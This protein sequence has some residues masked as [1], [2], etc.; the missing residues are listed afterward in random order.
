MMVVSIL[1]VVGSQ[2]RRH[3]QPATDR[4][5]QGTTPSSRRVTLDK[6]IGGGKGGRRLCGRIS[7]SAVY[8]CKRRCKMQKRSTD[9]PEPNHHQTTR[10][11]PRPHPEKPNRRNDP[12]PEPEETEPLGQRNRKKPTTRPKQNASPLWGPTENP[13]KTPPKK[14]PGREGLDAQAAHEVQIVERERVRQPLRR[15]YGK[16]NS[17]PTWHGRNFF[18]PRT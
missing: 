4:P 12:N 6:P 14:N 5:V 11:K 2:R 3:S 7:G 18:L 17:P 9:Q 10:T 15:D 13:P 1:D 16:K 8:L